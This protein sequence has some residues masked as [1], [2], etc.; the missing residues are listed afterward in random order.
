V[1]IPTAVLSIDCLLPLDMSHKTAQN[2]RGLRLFACA[3]AERVLPLLTDLHV[4]G[5]VE[6]GRNYALGLLSWE[7][8]KFAGTM[9]DQ[10]KVP[11]SKRQ[12]HHW[13][14]IAATA[15]AMT[16]LYAGPRTQGCTPEWAAIGAARIASC[17]ARLAEQAAWLRMPD[18]TEDA[19]VELLYKYVPECFDN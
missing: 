13:A 15:C 19:H 3:C 10:V 14:T 16:E 2:H 9:A 4:R 8:M 1:R 12:A 6:A 17:A 18:E 5:A 7:S 11:R